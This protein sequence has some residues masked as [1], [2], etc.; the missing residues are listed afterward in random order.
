M[1]AI[2]LNFT[3]IIIPRYLAEFTLVIEALSITN[4]TVFVYGRVES[5]REQ[6]C[7]WL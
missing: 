6:C 1:C 7:P 5:S 2:Q 4:N 3:S